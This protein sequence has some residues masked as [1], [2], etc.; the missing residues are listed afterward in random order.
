M[1]ERYSHDV[2]YTANCLLKRF[3]KNNWELLWS[4]WC[5]KLSNYCSYY[6]NEAGSIIVA[7]K[8][9]AHRKSSYQLSFATLLQQMLITCIAEHTLQYFNRTFLVIV[10]VWHLE[11][12]PLDFLLLVYRAR[13]HVQI[14][15][16]CFFNH[17]LQFSFTVK[18][19]AV[20]RQLHAS[21]CICM[22][23]QCGTR[24]GKLKLNYFYFF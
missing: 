24:Q 16:F 22:Y 23:T 7:Q 4:G 19:F 20:A 9:I 15:Y 13:L 3:V 5:G 6:R 1:V 12:L 11:N 2:L 18:L 14:K 10:L 21:R 8:I 17:Q